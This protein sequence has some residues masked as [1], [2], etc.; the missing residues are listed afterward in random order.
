M[1]NFASIGRVDLVVWLSEPHLGFLGERAR[2][3]VGRGGGGLGCGGLV[4]GGGHREVHAGHGAAAARGRHAAQ[5]PGGGHS[6]FKMRT[7]IIERQES[8]KQPRNLFWWKLQ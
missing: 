3:L 6:T 4:P 2:L 1:P 7:L 8:R 5:Q